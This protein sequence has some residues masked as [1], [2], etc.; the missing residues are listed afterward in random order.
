MLVGSLGGGARNWGKSTSPLRRRD[1]A[2]Q[3]TRN[4]P[5]SKRPPRRVCC[6]SEPS[7]P[8]T[9]AAER[10][11]IGGGRAIRT[12]Q[13]ASWSSTPATPPGLIAVAR[14]MPVRPERDR[15]APLDRRISLQQRRGSRGYPIT[16]RLRPR[17]PRDKR[18]NGF[19]R[20][21]PPLRAKETVGEPRFV[22]A[23]LLAPLLEGRLD[24]GLSAASGCAARHLNVVVTRTSDARARS[25]VTTGRFVELAG[26]RQVV[27]GST[28]CRAVPRSA[29]PSP[30]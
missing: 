22:E 15:R 18:I 8:T 28:T 7:I 26:R 17:A 24:P 13:G 30:P 2:Q 6:A 27:P 16:R 9:I 20:C 25:R 1:G 5:A 11:R 29:G 4:L 12:E 23:A 21:A 19:C 10:R 14:A 3:P